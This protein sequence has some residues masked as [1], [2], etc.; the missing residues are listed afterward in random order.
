MNEP[1]LVKFQALN[2]EIPDSVY[3][4]E[5]T[6]KRPLIKRISKIFKTVFAYPC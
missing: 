2:T 5:K 6:W 4:M 3:K 1:I